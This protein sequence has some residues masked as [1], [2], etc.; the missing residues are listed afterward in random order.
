MIRKMNTKYISD[1]IECFNRRKKEKYISHGS[2]ESHV[3]NEFDYQ[4]HWYE[5]KIESLKRHKYSYEK[6]KSPYDKGNEYA[7]ALEVT[8][9]ITSN[10]YPDHGAIKDKIEGHNS[11]LKD[12][13]IWMADCC[14]YDFY[15]NDHFVK[16]RDDLIGP[17]HSVP[18]KQTY[19]DKRAMT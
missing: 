11:R 17:E 13:V 2:L 7:V 12:L 9:G 18:W 15:A 6:K 4:I 19:L 16:E 5:S 1:G 3:N 14:D 8:E 10:L